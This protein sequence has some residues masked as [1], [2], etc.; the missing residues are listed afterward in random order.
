MIVTFDG[1]TG[2]RGSGKEKTSMPKAPKIQARPADDAA[3]RLST[4]E[5]PEC[6]MVC[7]DF[8]LGTLSMAVGDLVER[9]LE[10]L[11]LRLRH[12]RLLRLLFFEGARQQSSIG[13]VLGIDRTTVVA[14]VD[15]LEK[16]KLAKRVR[17][18]EDRRAYLVS[19]TEKGRR[20]SEKATQLVNAVEASMFSPLT[21]DEQD[22]VRKLSA[23]LLLHPGIIAEAHAKL[24]RSES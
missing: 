15:H 10:P 13:P 18:P 16:L 24:A 5:C 22:L 23:R 14:I 4:A 3:E 17:S 2:L 9:A 12:Y 19:I 11:D 20:V 8:V 7:P 6:L 21:G 1:G